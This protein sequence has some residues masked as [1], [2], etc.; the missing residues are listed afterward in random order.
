MF[1]TTKD[2]TQLNTVSF[3]SGNRTFLAI[4]G[5]V[6][7]WEVWLQVFE[8]LSKKW[9]C[10]SYDHRGSGQS[11]VLPEKISMETMIDD[12]I[13]VMDIL[14]I[15]R[16]IIGGESMGGRI[17]MRAVL[18]QPERFEGLILADSSALNQ[19]PQTEEGKAF[20]EFLKA[21]YAGAIEQFVISVLPE[22]DSDHYKRWGIDMCMATEPEAT[23]RM[24]ECQY[25]SEPV[26]N[27]REIEVPTLIIHGSEDST[28][29]I[30]NSIELS[31]TIPNAELLVIEGA[32]H[33]PIITRTEEVVEA[34]HRVFS[35]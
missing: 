10:V 9:R 26:Y 11:P 32:G 12:V 1:V 18:K 35:N 17:V 27:P 23:I 21:D 3:G 28:V 33:V 6:A 16:C 20:V 7:S 8:P 14:E 25:E 2:G 30:N 24:L 34:I 22:P 31:K 19:T 5:W 29:P 13:E 4:G 15:D